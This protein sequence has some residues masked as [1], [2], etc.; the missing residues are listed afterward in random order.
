MYLTLSVPE[1]RLEARALC[2]GSRLFAALSTLTAAGMERPAGD[3]R[4]RTRL[5]KARRPVGHC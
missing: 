4:L 1:E 2:D 5:N 3:F